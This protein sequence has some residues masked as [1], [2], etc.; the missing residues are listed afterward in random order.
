[1]RKETI[2]LTSKKYQMKMTQKLSKETFPNLASTIFM[3]KQ[4][5]KDN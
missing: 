4:R 3:E 2:Q 1:M 5:S